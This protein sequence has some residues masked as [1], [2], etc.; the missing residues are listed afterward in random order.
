MDQDFV[1]NVVVFGDPKVGKTS[2]LQSIVTGNVN[3]V[4]STES[5]KMYEMLNIRKSV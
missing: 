3:L 4:H 1:F 2:L 5:D